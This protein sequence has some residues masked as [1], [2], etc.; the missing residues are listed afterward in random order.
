MD[1][2][3]EQGA[4]Q[5]RLD[6]L[7]RFLAR[8]AP[9]PAGNGASLDQAA[10]EV[11]AALS[12]AGVDALL[13][14]GRGLATLLYGPGCDRSFSDVDLLVA[15]ADLEAAED[16]LAGLGYAEADGGIDDIGGVVHAQAWRR[17]AP[18]SDGDPPI[19]LHRRFPGSRADPAV[20]WVALLARRAWI[21]LGGRPAPVLDRVGQ[22][23]HL[24]TH[25]AQHGPAAV[26]HVHELELALASWPAEVW[27][28]AAVLAGEI[29]ATEPFA[30]GLRLCR[31]GAAVAAQLGLPGTDGLDWALR[32]RSERPPGTFHLQALA[33]VRSL[34]GRLDVLRRSLF[35]RREWIVQQHPWAR[36]GGLRVVAAY[37]LHL[38]M[39]PAWAAR[40]LRFRRRVRRAAARP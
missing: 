29:G 7:H 39:A 36:R 19:D 40:A 16:A 17:T 37:G 35:P 32:H 1:A 9:T 6:A 11:L 3:S 4:T 10:A 33:E 22:A 5:A 12:E 24:A 14:K 21:E 2:Q 30:A 27:E 13:L 25:A 18:R 38:A 23:M 26:K 34:R 8:V 31:R 28:S 20:T 15:P